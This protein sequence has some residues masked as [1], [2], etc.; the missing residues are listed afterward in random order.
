[1]LQQTQVSRVIPL[2]TAWLERW[3]TPHALAADSPAEAVRMWDRL[4]Y[5]RRALWLHQAAVE[6][7]ERHG[8]EVPG[9]VNALLAL[10][11]VGP[12]TAR[13]IA[14]FAYAMREPVV[15]T[16]TRRVIARAVNGR[17]A[18]GMPNE[19]IDL[20]DMSALLPADEASAQAFNAGIMEL[21]AVICTARAPHCSECPIAQSCAWKRA[22]FPENAPEKRP[23][24]ARFEGSDRQAR[25]AVLAVLRT[26]TGP[27]SDVALH[28]EWEDSAQ[29]GRA[30]ASL[31]SDGLIELTPNG[32]QLA[33]TTPA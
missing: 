5:P 27:V 23:R 9:D 6:L 17:A 24:Q 4:G 12:Y 18:A 11:G 25:G 21:G 33:G 29:L 7:V 3:P 10:K 2:L 26:A 1:M 32:F 31:L 14:A 13:A 19:R 8:G 20:A 15:D 30:I 16:N 28:R 22:G